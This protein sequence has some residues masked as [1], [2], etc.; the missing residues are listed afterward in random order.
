LELMEPSIGLN[1]DHLVAHLFRHQAGK[2]VATLTRVF[3]ARHLDLAEDVVQDA[4]VKALQ[5]WPFK[6]I[7]ENPA[8]W[9]TLV[10]RNRA[11]DLLR[12][13]SSLSHKIAELEQALPHSTTPLPETG[14]PKV[15]DQLT[16]MLM[17]SHPDLTIESQAA[18]TLKYACGFST[19]EVARAF[20]TPEP[21][22]AQR[23]IRARRQIR[24][25]GIAMD[26]PSAEHVSQRLDGL[27]RVLYLLFNEGYSATRGNDLVRADLC[28]EAIRLGNLLIRHQLLRRPLVHAL[29]ALMMLQAA[30]LPARTQSDGTLAILDQQD[31]SLWDQ[32]LIN[33]GLRHLGWS[34]AGETLSTYHLQ[35]E[36]AAFHATSASD[37]ETD[38]AAIVARYDELYELEP[39]PVVALNRAIAV[40]RWMGPHAGIR[41]L[42]E[43]SSHPAFRQYYLLPAV[44]GELWKQVG[45]LDRAKEAYLRALTYPC[46][47]PERRFIESRLELV[48]GQR[49]SN[50]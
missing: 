2:I 18:L 36:I 4:L 37:R 20:L 24:D 30:R 31:R 42:E 32:R 34:A 49:V 26:P 23:L 11:L 8:G 14:E 3:G 12:R 25:K 41:E 33:L 6:G 47:E 9:I 15:D 45:N 1:T 50:L 38:W 39:T 17:C 28:E 44:S 29:L 40:S 43:I 10:A 27:L 48:A 46:T 16:L 22:I 13:D 35:A 7:P 21:T 19:A 5:Q